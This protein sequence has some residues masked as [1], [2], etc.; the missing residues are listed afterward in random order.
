MFHHLHFMY[1]WFDIIPSSKGKQYKQE[2][3][4]K[5]LQYWNKNSC[6]SWVSFEQPGPDSKKNMTNKPFTSAIKG[7]PCCW[8][9]FFPILYLL[10]GVLNF[11]GYSISFVFLFQKY[12]NNRIVV[13]IRRNCLYLAIDLQYLHLWCECAGIVLNSLFWMV[14]RFLYFHDF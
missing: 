4:T 14:D 3:Q 6:L 13:L 1:M 8:E 2:N 9:H 11:S 10:T 12:G 7:S 5:K